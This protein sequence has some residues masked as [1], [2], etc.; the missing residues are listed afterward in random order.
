MTSP[1]IV[2]CASC[3]PSGAATARIFDIEFRESGNSQPLVAER[4][5]LARPLAGGERPR[6]D[7]ARK[8]HA[9]YQSRYLSD[10]GRL[11]FNSWDSLVPHDKNSTEDVYEYEPSGVGSCASASPGC[12]GDDLLRRIAAKN[13][14]SS[15]PAKTA[16]TC[17]S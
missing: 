16:A 5:Q 13:P 11:F 1:R 3:N 8:P 12:I 2:V 17:S 9:L 14:R 7:A 10:N 6:L 15:T 4:R